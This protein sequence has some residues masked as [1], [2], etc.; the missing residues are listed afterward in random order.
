MKKITETFKKTSN[1]VRKIANFLFGKDHSI[2]HRIIVGIAVM[3]VGVLI[4]HIGEDEYIKYLA[5]GVGF[6]I[7]GVGLSP[8]AEFLLTPGE[9]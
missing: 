5:E 2:T 4:S 9:V 3:G 8:I 6:A 1:P 7:H